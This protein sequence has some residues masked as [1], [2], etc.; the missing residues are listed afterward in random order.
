MKWFLFLTFFPALVWARPE[1]ILPSQV[2]IS[3]RSVVRLGDIAE[4]QQGNEDLLDSLDAIALPSQDRIKAADIL[5]L[6]KE[7]HLN[8]TF[9][10]PALVVMTKSSTPISKVEVERRVLNTLSARCHECSYKIN[11][12]SAPYP[13]NT[14]WDLDF[15]QLS[16]RGSFLIP[17]R[18]GGAGNANKWVSGTVRVSRLTP[19]ATRLLS[20][21][22]RIQPGDLKLAPA[23]VTFAKDSGLR[24]EDIVGQQLVRTIQVGQP[25][26]A[27]DVKR[28][29]AAKRGQIV[30]GTLGDDDFQI[31][32][33]VE[34]QDSG[35]IGDVIK[36]KNL[37]TQKLLSAV[38]VD[39]GVVKVQ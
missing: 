6:V 13:V 26:W 8:A 29:P 39:K 3:Q 35:Y 12:L 30:K 1:V 20:L 25:V 10:I 36:V 32:L 16:S 5:N 33:N 18:E 9:R 24:I 2:E 7:Q 31:S 37:E 21:G 22:E 28:E 34:A 15:S 23:D 19:V 27:A 14:Q 38:I 4:V 11:V 17:V